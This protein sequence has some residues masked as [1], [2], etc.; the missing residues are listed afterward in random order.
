MPIIVDG[1]NLLHLVQKTSE[2]SGEITDVQMCHLINDYLRL[3][4]ESGEIIFDGIGPP[5]KSGFDHISNLEIV[6]VGS[7]TDADTVIENKIIASSASKR[8]TI[9]S[10]DRRVRNAAKAR[11]A[12][13]LKSETFWDKLQKQ[14]S[15]KRTV[16]EP[17]E[18][19][20]GLNKSE[21][22]QWIKFF[23]LDQ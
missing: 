8:L 1:Y 14:L 5:E 7:H 10:S 21:T 17:A 11:K 9:V 4:N 3:I 13:S 15:R 22:D 20:R 23:G 16:R 6:F 19:R 12:V 2:D 18:K